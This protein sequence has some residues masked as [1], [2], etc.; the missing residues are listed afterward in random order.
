MKLFKQLGLQRSGTNALRAIVETNLPDCLFLANILGDKHDPQSWEEMEAW[1]AQNPA[2]EGLT[3][4]L[5][6]QMAEAVYKRRL[7]V[8][9]SIKDPVSWL[10]SYFRYAK[11]KA[12][13]SN[14]DQA[15]LLTQDFADRF[16]ESW[17]D[18]MTRYLQFALEN[19]E[20]TM[21]V[22]HEE[23]LRS[24]D[25]VLARFCYTFGLSQ[26]E[27]T[28]LFQHGYARRGIERQ[29][30]KD[31]IN[32]KVKFDRS[33]HLE[34]R[35]AMEMPQKFYDQGVQVRRSY[36]EKHPEFRP[37]FLAETLSD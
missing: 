34:G 25:A 19:K 37:F 16:L 31:L 35:W 9:I 1:L 23:L 13:Y 7:D 27:N 32:A 14:P 29:H 15:F 6:K 4:D 3:P 26:P 18:R 30:G 5:Y 2:V 33:Y 21:V 20:R 12:E 24:P 8:V 28:E 11:K 36:F 10:W 22:Q 17:S